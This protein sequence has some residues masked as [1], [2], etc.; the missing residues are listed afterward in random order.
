MI[1]SRDRPG[2]AG[3]IAALI[4]LFM[5]IAPAFQVVAQT[6]GAAGPPIRLAPKGADTA[7]PS[8][9]DLPAVQVGPPPRILAPS[10]PGVSKSRSKSEDSRRLAPVP[11]GAASKGSKEIEVGALEA[12][13]PSSIGLLSEEQGGLGLEMWAGTRRALVERLLPRLP[14]GTS[15]RAMQSLARRLLL[16]TAVA[17]EEPARG[18]SLLAL[19]VERLAA[20]GLSNDTNALLELVP[21][22]LND[23]ALARAR[24]DSL[25][26]AGDMTR[27]CAI[28][29]NLVEQHGD[30]IWQKAS[31]FCHAL[32]G[33]TSRVELYEQLLH[34]VGHEDPAFFILLAALTGRDAPPLESL[35]AAM[36]LHLAMLRSARRA[37]PEDAA[38]NA[39]PLILR[40]I[41][42][43]A[44]AS[45]SLRLVAAERAAAAGALST[46]ALRQIY[47]G[48]PFT[49]EERAGALNIVENEP[50]A[51]S[52]ALLYQVAGLEALPSG[53]ARTLQAAF[54]RAT[55]I[56]HI[57][58]IARTNKAVLKSLP[59]TPELS[60]FASDAGRA[61]LVV[62]EV[63][64][65]LDWLMMARNSASAN[66]TESVRVVLDLWPL[67]LI[68]DDRQ[69]VPFEPRILAKWWQAQGAH[70]AAERFARAGLFYAL[71]EALGYSVP[72]E[73]WAELYDA[74][75]GE[76]ESAPPPV[77][78]QGLAKAS[79]AVRTGETVLLALLVLDEGGP[80]AASAT[81]LTQVITSLRRLGLEQDARAVALEAMLAR[82]F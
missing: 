6:G 8:K 61:L 11:R 2:A 50:G 73:S 38:E 16:S 41:A 66:S 65:A 42:L 45:P 15:S 62:G 33:Q 32:D 46:K 18:P 71:L 82:G 54:R 48:M 57:A 67:L 36:P 4:G 26:L 1:V 60:W 56:D 58:M 74:A 10:P 79:D 55:A 31:A 20:G 40:A 49:L 78:Q 47:D 29:R 34:E 44:S 7:G 43:S 77:L 14:M 35:R 69:R 17:P 75:A 30:P 68:G 37:V 53:R 28:A 81:T 9:S 13:D 76:S 21:P 64:G 72:A 12:V 24:L 27:A 80:A 23:V 19:R 63:G 25:L 39:T 5:A 70:E 51:I 59:P 22:G 52:N 3:V